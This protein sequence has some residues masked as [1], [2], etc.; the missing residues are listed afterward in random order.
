MRAGAIICLSGMRGSRTGVFLA[1]L[2]AVALVAG[3]GGG[4]KARQL[5]VSQIVA[6]AAANT[7]QVKSFHFTLKVEHPA[8]STSGLSLTYADGDVVVP[9]RLKANVAGTLSGVPL[10]STLVFIGPTAFI[11]NPFGGSWQKVP[12]RT[13]PVAFFDPAKGVLAVIKGSI[14]L[15]LAGS[16]TVDGVDAYDLEGQVPASALTAILGNP[17]S[18][19]LAN[20]ELLVGKDDLLLRRIQLSSRIAPAEPGNIVR[21]VDVSRFDEKISIEAPQAG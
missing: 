18:D 20:V 7:A 3:C 8:P 17:P 21:R 10:K 6:K 19:R 11:K 14:R 15:K 1:S 2:V 9:D 5:S 16:A 13:S 12:V 4:K